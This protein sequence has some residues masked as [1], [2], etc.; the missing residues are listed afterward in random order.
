MAGGIDDGGCAGIG[1]EDSVAV[2]TVGAVAGGRAG[3]VVVAGDGLAAPPAAAAY[4]IGGR[5]GFTGAFDCGKPAFRADDMGCA[6]K[7]GVGTGGFGGSTF[8]TCPITTLREVMSEIRNN[9]RT[10]CC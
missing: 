2:L 10:S 1:D 4:R 6:A 3:G 7:F 9:G 8:S 5:T